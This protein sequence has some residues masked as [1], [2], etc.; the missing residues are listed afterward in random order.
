M[1]TCGRLRQIG[2][3]LDLREVPLAQRIHAISKGRRITIQF[4]GCHPGKG[5]IAAF[6]RFLQQFQPDFRLG[7]EPQ[8]FGHTARL[9][10]LSLFFI[11]PT[12]GHK[13]LSLDQTV[14]F[15]TGVSQIHTHLSVRN[16]AHRAAILPCHPDRFLP[17]LTVLD[18]SIKATPSFSPKVSPIKPW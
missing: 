18:S 11:E 14:P 7:L 1:Y 10:S 3:A 17:C 13:Q 12:F 16:L 8:V 4:I 6:L 15:A 5:Q 9:S 2:G